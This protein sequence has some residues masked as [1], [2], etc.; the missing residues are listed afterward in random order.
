MQPPPPPPPPPSDTHRST[1][2]TGS[3]YLCRHCRHAP[4]DHRHDNEQWHCR[5]DAFTLR[6]H[7]SLDGRGCWSGPS[8]A[9]RWPW[10]RRAASGNTGPSEGSRLWN[11]AITL[12]WRCKHQRRGATPCRADHPQRT[13]FTKQRQRNWKTTRGAEPGQGRAG[14]W[15]DSTHAVQSQRRSNCKHWFTTSYLQPLPYLVTP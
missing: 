5:P 8:A 2:G 14:S 1:I 15:T 7:F 9:L 13:P 4:G 12:G 3:I 11:T 10:R 6:K